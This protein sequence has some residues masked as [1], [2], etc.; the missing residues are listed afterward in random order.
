MA[1]AQG[2]PRGIHGA[3]AQSTA[4]FWMSPPRHQALPHHMGRFDQVKGLSGS[5]FPHV[6]DEHVEF[7][8]RF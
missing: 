8:F 3:G 6:H 1:G 2:V 7:N 5:R 4:H